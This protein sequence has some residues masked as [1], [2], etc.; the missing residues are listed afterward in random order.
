MTEVGQIVAWFTFFGLVI[1]AR[2]LI[3]RP[4]HASSA[5]GSGAWPTGDTPG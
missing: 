1:L 3:T 2:L 4:A 5:R